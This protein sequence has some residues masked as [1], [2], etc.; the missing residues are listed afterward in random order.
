MSSE[1]SMLG[2][3][4]VAAAADEVVGVPVR[5]KGHQGNYPGRGIHIREQSFM[6]LWSPLMILS[7]AEE[8]VVE[9]QQLLLQPP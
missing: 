8:V 9:E 7:V 6:L 5:G 2:D 4:V 1:L 3:V